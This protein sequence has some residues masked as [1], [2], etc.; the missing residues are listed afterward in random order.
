MLSLRF[1]C[2]R[3]VG[4][5]QRGF[6]AIDTCFG[7]L[8]CSL[9]CYGGRKLLIDALSAAPEGVHL[10]ICPGVAIIYLQYCGR[11]SFSGS[12][13]DEAVYKAACWAYK[14]VDCPPEV[15]RRLEKYQ[16]RILI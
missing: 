2:R 14:R 3:G 7:V 5:G 10:T 4:N 11:P 9:Y 15:M 12:T 13:L 1:T 6:C 8:L 16:N